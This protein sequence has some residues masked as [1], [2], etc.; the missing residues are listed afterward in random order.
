MKWG[1]EYFLGL[2][3]MNNRFVWILNFNI[4]FSF[5]SLY[6]TTFDF[7]FLL[8]HLKKGKINYF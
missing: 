5:Y 8:E 1:N 7:S 6:S 3:N 2:E 4:F